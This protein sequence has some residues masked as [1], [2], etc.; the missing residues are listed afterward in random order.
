MVNSYGKAAQQRYDEVILTEF[1]YLN[2]HINLL[3]AIR[4]K[5]HHMLKSAS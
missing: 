1:S 2:L 5:P 4:L 3:V